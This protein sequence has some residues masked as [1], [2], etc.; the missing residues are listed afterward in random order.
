MTRARLIL[1]LIIVTVAL[2]GV[3]IAQQAKG[4]SA[5]VALQA[6][7]K[8]ETIDGNLQAAIELYRKLADGADRAVV[9]Q[10]LVRMGQCYEKL[11]ATQ[12]A[13]ARKAYERVVSQYGDQ[14]DFAA[15]ARARLAAMAAGRASSH[16]R[17][18]PR[19]SPR[20]PGQPILDRCFSTAEANRRCAG[21]TVLTFSLEPVSHCS[22]R[23]VLIF[24]RRGNGCRSC[25]V[26]PRT[27]RQS[28]TR[29]TTL[30]RG[31]LRC[32]VET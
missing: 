12:S 5:A 11:G 21:S 22:R 25:R 7:I 8:V 10:A 28:T 4:A 27:A 14:S 23:S 15:Q 19:R 26:S 20:T 30:K 13:E 18:S 32:G 2:A 3:G 9:A 17:F 29:R 24:G 31:W 16:R 6:A 1:V